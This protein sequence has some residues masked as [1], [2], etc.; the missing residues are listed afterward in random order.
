MRRRGG[1]GLMFDV[2]EGG[3]FFVVLSCCTYRY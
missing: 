3:T 1:R 2:R